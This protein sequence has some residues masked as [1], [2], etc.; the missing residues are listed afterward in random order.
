MEI[1]IIIIINFALITFQFYLKSSLLSPGICLF[2]LQCSILLMSIV[3]LS[4]C[5]FS[6]GSMNPK[7]K[8]EQV[9]GFHAKAV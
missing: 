4:L 9:P 7:M 6:E 2:F 1:I 8:R 5:A 3:I